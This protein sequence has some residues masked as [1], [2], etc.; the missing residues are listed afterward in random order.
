MTPRNV[1]NDFDLVKCINRVPVGAVELLEGG[2]SIKENSARLLVFIED[3]GP[4]AA[5]MSGKPIPRHICAMTLKQ[6]VPGTK[7]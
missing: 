3:L 4:G 5:E 2:G 6:S 1:G 7:I